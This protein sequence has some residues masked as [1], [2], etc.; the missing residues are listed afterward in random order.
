MWTFINV[1]SMC[2][3]ARN[4]SGH[5]LL[6]RCYLHCGMEETANPAIICITCHPVFCHLSEHVSSSMEKT[7]LDIVHIAKLKKFTKSKVIKLTILTVDVLTLAI[8]KMQESRGIT[9]VNVQSKFIFH[10]QVLSILTEL[11][12]KTLQTGS[13]GYSNC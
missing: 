12:D 1:G 5:E 3:I 2:P 9:I 11:I 6:W 7:M 13:K 8:L 4:N 10:I